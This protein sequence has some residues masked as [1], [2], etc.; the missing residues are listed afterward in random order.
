MAFQPSPRPAGSSHILRFQGSLRTG[1]SSDNASVQGGVPVANAF[2]T[3]NFWLSDLTDPT[4]QQTRLPANIFDD[5]DPA[6]GVPH[7]A[8]G[9]PSG[10]GGFS[11]PSGRTWMQNIKTRLQEI[12]TSP[13]APRIAAVRVLTP[14]GGSSA[15][16]GALVQIL[17]AFTAA[18]VAALTGGSESAGVPVIVEIEIPFTSIR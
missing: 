14:Q 8:S 18:G 7:L 5:Q 9:G 17:V 3:V 10:I 15:S 13:A 2:A 16:R 1:T 12:T 6:Q 11:D 4:D